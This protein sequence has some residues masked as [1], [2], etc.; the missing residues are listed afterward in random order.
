MS[1]IKENKTK[2]SFEF[3]EN[4]NKDSDVILILH[5]WQGASSSWTQVGKKL[6][7]N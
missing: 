5:G 1:E 7:E 2:L 3:F 4:E 6:S